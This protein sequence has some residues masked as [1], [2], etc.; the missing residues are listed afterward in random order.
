MPLRAPFRYVLDVG[1]AADVGVGKGGA[2]GA[3]RRRAKRWGRSGRAYC[4][5]DVVLAWRYA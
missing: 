2:A 5:L 4:G 3:G 1:G